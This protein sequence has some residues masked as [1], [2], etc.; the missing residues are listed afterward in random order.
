[1]QTSGVAKRYARAAFELALEN[2]ELDE[3]LSELKAAA[4]MIQHPQVAEVLQNVKVPRVD[5]TQLMARLLPDLR[6]LV[7][8]LILLLVTKDRTDIVG[9]IIGEFEQLLNA[10]RGIAVAEVTTALPVDE[11]EK[12]V[13]IDRLSRATGKRI[14]LHTRVDPQIMGGLVA[15]IGD[16]LIDGSLKTRLLVLRRKLVGVT[17]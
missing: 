11:G 13:L 4:E 9:Q 5:K 2:N 16:K 3:W 12:V 17:R 8:N 15:K 1:M 7:R 10:H 14:V 6:P